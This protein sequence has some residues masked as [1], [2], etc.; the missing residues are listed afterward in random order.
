MNRFRI[1]FLESGLWMATVLSAIDDQSARDA[2][3]RKH[4]G[5]I[6]LGLRRE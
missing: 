6:L 5:A 4:P 2:F 1:H 3:S